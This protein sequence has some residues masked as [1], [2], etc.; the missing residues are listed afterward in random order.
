MGGE[1]TSHLALETHIPVP[2]RSPGRPHLKVLPSTFLK[3]RLVSS[4]SFS[5]DGEQEGSQVFLKRAG[6]PGD[7][8]SCS[9]QAWPWRAAGNAFPRRSGKQTTRTT[10]RLPRWLRRDGLV[11]SA[12]SASSATSV[13][14]CGLTANVSLWSL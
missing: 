4:L 7:D 10:A 14:T 13:L 3:L 12:S 2:Y 11:P 1:D 5:F 8:G 6:C 9:L